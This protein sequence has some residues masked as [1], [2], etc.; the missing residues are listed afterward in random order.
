MDLEV[1][2]K[3]GLS[4]QPFGD[5]DGHEQPFRI[6]LPNRRVDAIDVGK[7]RPERVVLHQQPHID[8]SIVGSLKAGSHDIA[9][10]ALTVPGLPDRRAGLLQL[11]I[12]GRADIAELLPAGLLANRKSTHGRALPHLAGFTSGPRQSA[13]ST[14]STSAVVST[15]S[16]PARLGCGS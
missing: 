3:S 7:F 11:E 9:A 16:R 4:A 5:R 1:D 15:L 12:V 6:M 13:T 14:G 8:V 2:R 10:E